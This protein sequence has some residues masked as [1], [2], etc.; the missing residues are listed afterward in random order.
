MRRLLLIPLLSLCL[1]SASFAQDDEPKLQ[2]AP[3]A[4]VLIDGALYISPQKEMF[5]DGMAISEAR[6]GAKMSYGKWSAL[7][8]VAYS[9]SK[10]GLRNMWIEY[11]FN[12]H[13]R[14]RIGNFIQPFGL[15]ST[16]SKSLKCT[17]EQPIAADI[18]TPGIQLGAMY[19]YT[20]P[21]FWGAAAFHVESS[22]L[23]NAMNAPLFNQQGYGILG[24]AVWRKS[25]GNSPILQFGLSAEFATPQRRLENNEDVHDGF[26]I[27]VNY[28]TKV[29]QVSAVGT[30]VANSKN[31]F[32][33]S[34]EFLVAK[35]R[36]AA[37]G[38]YFFQTISRRKG[39]NSYQSQS[40]YVLLRG[41]LTRGSYAYSSGL[42]DLARPKPGS[43]EC[44]LNYN[45]ITL[46]DA[47]AN[48]FGGRANNFNATLNYYINPYVTARLNYTYTHTWDREGYTPVT[49]SGI[50]AR[51]MVLF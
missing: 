41:L 13:H 43:L 1:S 6:I 42:A 12:E 48:I 11:N 26:T 3:S 24:R 51:I 33:F 21:S 40:G 25:T 2:I 18:F 27:S 9:Y 22:A 39:L 14:F 5:P 45:Y 37:Q 30:T 36:L 19:G 46:S 38:Q 4:R 28:P 49:M 8:D 35:G 29:A 17:F 50:Q 10:I 23:S 16:Y 47:G 31:L 44:V 34:P 7:M 32:K 20:N 15:E